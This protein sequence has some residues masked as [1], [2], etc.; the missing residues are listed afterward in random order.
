M[1]EQAFFYR[2]ADSWILLL[3]E[4]ATY[5]LT[6]DVDVVPLL[7]QV[8][9]AAGSYV[10]LPIPEKSGSTFDGWYLN[11]ICFV[12]DPV[13]AVAMTKDITVYAKWAA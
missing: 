3:L 1:T 11:S 12:G 2:C 8:D 10:T 4:G 7:A 6:Y 5:T 13:S 9:Y